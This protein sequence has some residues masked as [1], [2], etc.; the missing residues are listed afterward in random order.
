M[1]DQVALCAIEVYELEA[2]A[3]A[4]PMTEERSQ[5]KRFRPVRQRELNRGAGPNGELTGEQHPHAFLVE[6]VRAAMNRSQ[7]VGSDPYS[8]VNLVASDFPAAQ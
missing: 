3:K 1:A 8:Q 5:T 6:V 7:A 2:A 4:L